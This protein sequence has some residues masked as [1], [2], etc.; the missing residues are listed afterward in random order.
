MTPTSEATMAIGSAVPVAGMVT[1]YDATDDLE[2]VEQTKKGDQEAFSELVRRHQQ[3]TYNLAYRYMR[4]ATQ[5]EDMAQ[6]AFLKAFRLLHGFRGDSSFSTWLYRVTCS[7]CLTELNRRKR[8]GEVEL[9]PV[10]Y[11]NAAIQPSYTVDIP[12]HIRRCVTKLSDRYAEIVTLY[13][14]KGVSYDEIAETMDIPLGTLKTWM[15]RAR[16]QL[17]GIVEKEIYADGQ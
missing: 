12:D 15:F 3:V 6:E 14:L 17:R 2:L 10:H 16:K 7:V 5:A 13:Y 1:G 8:R 4:D 11:K 9:Q